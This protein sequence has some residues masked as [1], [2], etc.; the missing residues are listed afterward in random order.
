MALCKHR[1]I[2]EYFI[3]INEIN[4]HRVLIEILFENTNNRRYL[5]NR[6]FLEMFFVIIKDENNA[7]EV[8]YSLL[9]MG[10]LALVASTL[11]VPYLETVRRVWP[12]EKIPVLLLFDKSQYPSREDVRSFIDDVFVYIRDRKSGTI[13]I[14]QT[15]QTTVYFWAYDTDVVSET[16]MEKIG[17]L[18]IVLFICKDQLKWTEDNLLPF[19]EFRDKTL[20]FLHIGS[21]RLVV[22]KEITTEMNSSERVMQFGSKISHGVYCRKWKKNS[23]SMIQISIGIKM[24]L[25]SE[26]QCRMSER[27]SENLL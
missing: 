25:N 22:I 2:E 14:S 19:I 9:N 13:D 17:A 4:K 10:D 24:F 8:D 12:P 21:R 5:R 18:F 26:T 6:G 1:R 23:E 20:R 11:H 7:M 15:L 16:L 3:W 27:T